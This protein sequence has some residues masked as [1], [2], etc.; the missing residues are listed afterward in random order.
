MSVYK[1]D[2]PDFLQTALESIYDKQSTSAD[3]VSQMEQSL[4]NFFMDNEKCDNIKDGEGSANDTMA[5]SDKYLVYVVYK[6]LQHISI[7]RSWLETA[8]RLVSPILMK[9]DSVVLKGII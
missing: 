2:N 9:N 5:D 6:E 3:N 1:N 8:K 7:E 4:I